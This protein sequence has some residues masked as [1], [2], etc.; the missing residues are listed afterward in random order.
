[1]YF[2]LKCKF[3]YHYHDCSPGCT[4]WKE[5][6]HDCKVSQDTHVLYLPL[7]QQCKICIWNGSP[8]NKI[9]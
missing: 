5:W 6:F 8:R 3:Y 1:M 9:L 2:N 4:R 7:R